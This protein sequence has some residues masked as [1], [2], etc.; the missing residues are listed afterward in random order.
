MLQIE[1]SSAVPSLAARG[2]KEVADLFLNE[3]EEAK[4]NQAT[5]ARDLLSG[6]IAQ[7][8]AEVAEADAKVEAFRSDSGLLD[9]ANGMTAPSQQLAEITQP[10]S[11]RRAPRNRS[12]RPRRS[13]CAKCCARDET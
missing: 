13:C 7:L 3:K 8:R 2:A 4:K 6:K 11:L 5:A 9:L 10:R 1:F 12:R